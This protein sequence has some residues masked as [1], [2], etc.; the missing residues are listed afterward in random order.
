MKLKKLISMIFIICCSLSSNVFAQQC[1]A[2]ESYQCTLY[3]L[4]MTWGWLCMAMACKP[5]SSSQASAV[6]NSSSC[7]QEKYQA[8]H[9]FCREKLGKNESECTDWARN[10]CQGTN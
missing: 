10:S 4:D 2:G 7:T 6:K 5:N 8:A 9:Q 1:P 3:K